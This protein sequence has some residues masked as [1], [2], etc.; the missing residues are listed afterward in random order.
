MASKPFGVVKDVSTKGNAGEGCYAFV[1]DSGVLATTGDLLV[2]KAWSR[3]WVNG[4]SAF[5]DGNGHGTHVAGTIAALANNRGVVGVAPGAEVISLK[6][7]D[8][9]GGGASYSKV[10][11][12]VNYATSVINQN[13]LDKNK[14][15]INMSLG[16]GFSSGLDQAVRNAANQGIKFAIA[17][18]NAGS[19][20]DFWSPA[21]AG[22]HP[23]V[24]T[25]SA[26][27]NQYRMASWSNWDD[28][29]GGDDVDVAAPGV[30]VLSYYQGGN[31][32]YLSGT[33]MAAPHVAGLL[34]MGNGKLTEGDMVQA[35]ASGHSDP[36]A[37]IAANSAPELTGAKATLAK[38]KE[39][40]DYIIQ[41]SDLL[42]GFSDPDGD[43]LRVENLKADAGSLKNNNN[44][45]WTYTPE[46]NDN[47]TIKLSYTVS[48]GNGSSLEATN[49]FELEAVNDAPVV[50]GP[51][52]LGAIDED[53]SIRITKEANLLKIQ[54]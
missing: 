23:N 15:V 16:G 37:L 49:S 35:N 44:G 6:I 31:L 7:F 53:N 12:A 17:A 14:C 48:D 46:A 21:S 39:D 47:G 25:V 36:F 29:T 28:P 34:L 22:D 38:G 3:S 45:T 30:R 5:T 43:K 50:S 9:F 20:A 24:Y 54:L 4:E 52:D 51:V 33:S 32:R 42:K 41:E 2:N 19:D 10:I 8:S 27:D 1:I 40:T 18:G 13:G 11:D 26:V